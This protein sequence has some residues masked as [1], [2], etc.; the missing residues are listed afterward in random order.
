MSIK[1]NIPSYLQP[2]ANTLE[3]VEVNGS[4]V[5]ECLNYL[6]KQFPD[7]DKMLLDKDGKLLSYVGVYINEEDAYP[8]EMA[9]P[10]K[11][12]DNIQILYI[13]GGG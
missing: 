8:D 9:K 6:I 11:G 1:I 3:T 10:V 4:T 7:M 12:G 5:G 2:F 13:V